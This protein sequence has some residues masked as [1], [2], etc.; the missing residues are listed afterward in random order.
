M[1]INASQGWLNDEGCKGC[2]SSF[3]GF[4][5]FCKNEKMLI[6]RECVFLYGGCDSLGLKCQKMKLICDCLARLNEML[7]LA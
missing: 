2:S 3:K 5:E 1:M 6:E 4:A 7:N